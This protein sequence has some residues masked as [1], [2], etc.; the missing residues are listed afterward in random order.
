MFSVNIV[1]IGSVEF[2]D[3]LKNVSLFWPF[4]FMSPPLIFGYSKGCFW[5]VLFF[6]FFSLG[7]DEGEHSVLS[8]FNSNHPWGC[9]LDVP[10]PGSLLGCTSSGSSASPSCRALSIYHHS[11]WLVSNGLLLA[12][13][14]VL[15][16]PGKHPIHSY[17]GYNA[18]WNGSHCKYWINVE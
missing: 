4:L 3:F 7:P 16:L 2:H 8:S 14:G 17:N 18:A 12:G 9:I 11:V 13:P 5:N 6:F 1:L 15:K 10:P